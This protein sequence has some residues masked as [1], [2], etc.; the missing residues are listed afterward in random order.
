MIYKQRALT[1]MHY[2]CFR[3]GTQTSLPQTN[4][5]NVYEQLNRGEEGQAVTP[6]NTLG[7]RKQTFKKIIHV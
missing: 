4:N 6:Y 2:H 3:Q 1:M 7:W 5:P